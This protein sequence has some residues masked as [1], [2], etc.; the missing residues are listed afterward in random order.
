MA[1]RLGLPQHCRKCTED[2]LLEA[3]NDHTSET[4]IHCNLE[5]EDKPQKKKLGNS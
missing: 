1:E 5:W 4:P 2:P 3:T